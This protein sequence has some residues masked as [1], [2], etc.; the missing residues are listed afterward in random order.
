VAKEYLSSVRLF[1]VD[2]SSIFFAKSPKAFSKAPDEA[3]LLPPLRA[4]G[5]AGV[6]SSPLHI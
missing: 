1:F 2:F 5:E 3:A 4:A 6:G